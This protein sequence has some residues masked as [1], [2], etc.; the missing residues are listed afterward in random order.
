MPPKQPSDSIT[1]YDGKKWGVQ[2]PVD[3]DA[4]TGK[5]IYHRA[6]IHGRL[7][8]A[9]AY[10]SQVLASV[11]P[12]KVAPILRKKTPRPKKSKEILRLEKRLRLYRVEVLDLDALRVRCA[13]CNLDWTIERTSDGRLP[14]QY[15]RCPNLARGACAGGRCN[16]GPTRREV[17]D[18]L[19]DGVGGRP[20]IRSWKDVR[21]YHPSKLSDAELIVIWERFDWSGPRPLL[22]NE[23]IS[24]GLWRQA[25]R[26]R[27]YHRNQLQSQVRTFIDCV[28]GVLRSPGSPRPGTK[29]ASAVAQVK[30]IKESG[31]LAHLR[32]ALRDIEE[33]RARITRAHDTFAP[34]HVSIP[35]RLLV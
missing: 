34:T 9:E 15:W 14:R 27:M 10:R 18:A 3:R 20:P 32:K 6:T 12:E 22:H 30:T 33:L 23:L 1:R 19:I 7:R 2:I 11:P 26:R 5:L 16:P 8:D 35:D 29:L 21:A 25:L 17:I 28:E 24:R 4:I 13:V 31:L